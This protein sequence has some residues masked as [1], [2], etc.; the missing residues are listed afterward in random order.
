MEFKEYFYSK[1]AILDGVLIGTDWNL[2]ENSL[3][4]FLDRVN[5]VLIGTDWN[6]K[7]KHLVDTTIMPGRINRNRLE[8]KEFCKIWFWIRVV[9]G[10]NRNRLEFK[11][12]QQQHLR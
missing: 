9:A 3:T 11:G 2:K 6:L 7:F 8:F 1:T 4:Q 5:L 10:I 12:S